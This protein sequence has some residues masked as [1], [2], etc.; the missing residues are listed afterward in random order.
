MLK[1]TFFKQT[2]Y[3]VILINFKTVLF[4]LKYVHSHLLYQLVVFHSP[5]KFFVPSI[6]AKKYKRVLKHELSFF[7]CR[8][9]IIQKEKKKKNRKNVLSQF[10]ICR[11]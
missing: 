3:F 2:D 7:E 6:K 8:K 5:R 1:S 4:C 9:K 10:T 11:N